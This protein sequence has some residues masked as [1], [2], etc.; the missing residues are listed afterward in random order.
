MIEAVYVEFN[1][2]MD[3]VHAYIVCMKHCSKVKTKNIV[4]MQ[5]LESMSD[6]RNVHTTYHLRLRNK[7]LTKKQSNSSNIIIG[8]PIYKCM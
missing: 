3:D 4:T 2:R 1:K 7:F 6:K 5:N 8:L